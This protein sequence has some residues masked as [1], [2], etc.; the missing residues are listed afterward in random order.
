MET[1][2]E[3][4]AAGRYSIHRLV[5]SG[6]LGHV[7]LA[8]DSE[9]NRWVAVK[10]L[11]ADSEAGAQRAQAVLQEARHLAALQHPN[12]VT[13][14]D[15]LKE[16]EDTLV[17]MEYLAG[18][19]LEEITAEAPLTLEDFL[20]VARQCLEGL[21][22]AHARGLLHRDIKPSNIMV[23]RQASG[24]LEVKIL[25]FGLAKFASHPLEQSTDHTGS[26]LGS[27]YTMAPEQ[28]ERR[29]LD[30]RTDLYSLGCVFYQCLA[31]RPPFDGSSV[32]EVMAAHL[33]HHFVPL[34]SQRPDVPAALCSWV[35]RLF[36]RE[37]AERPASARQ[38]SGLLRAIAEGATSRVPPAP[39]QQTSNIWPLAAAGVAAVVLAA[40][41][42][43]FLLAPKISNAPPPATLAAEASADVGE[44]Q[45][46]PILPSPAPTLETFPASATQ[47]LLHRIG[48]KVVVE[49]TVSRIGESRSGDVLYVNFLGNARGDLSLVRFTTLDRKEA[50]RTQLDPLV[51]QRIRAEGV[52]TEYRGAPQ[53]ELRDFSQIQIQPES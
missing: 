1:Q 9:L 39:A 13:V 24:A 35:E 40:G 30:A 53:L 17:V 42:G 18:R 49:G 38:A 33:H 47:E 15:C 3:T 37:P 16:G 34:A 25:D 29:P 44:S 20:S 43:W 21:A 41:A 19:T 10:R 46:Q 36:A 50:D 4:L 23:V 14:Y 5:G 45:P 32:A 48:Q 8:Y 12:I 52:I 22:A 28:F 2:V 7:Y 51:G 31:G 11:R 26:L 27:I 6:G